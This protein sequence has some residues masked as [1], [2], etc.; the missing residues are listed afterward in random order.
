MATD[1]RVSGTSGIW[2]EADAGVQS[3]TLL[4]GEGEDMAVTQ[5]AKCSRLF[6]EP[7]N[8]S[9]SL[10][11]LRTRLAAPNLKSFLLFCSSSQ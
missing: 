11:G 4:L 6:L 9:A 3:E 2:N 7:A 8:K 5:V 10:N 1:T